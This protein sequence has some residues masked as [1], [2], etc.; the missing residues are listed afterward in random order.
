MDA[1]EPAK[2]CKFC[3][4][5]EEDSSLSFVHP[6]RCRGSI[7]WVH[8]RCLYLWFSKTS[9]IQQVMC[10]Q[11]QTRYQKQ[12]TLKPFRMWR[13]PRFRCDTF[14][15]IEILADMV[16]TYKMITHFVGMLDGT[17]TILSEL[18]YFFL[19][20]IGIVSKGRLCFYGNV[21]TRLASGIFRMSIDDY[22]ERRDIKARLP[23]DIDWD[24][25]SGAAGPN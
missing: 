24:E 7:H 13:F 20:R 2:Y 12:L 22:E 18:L 17:N 9:A 6:C 3:F 23:S 5:T 15:A 8:H 10:T 21:G 25:I 4:G 16:V 11:C 1:E 14:S 19:W